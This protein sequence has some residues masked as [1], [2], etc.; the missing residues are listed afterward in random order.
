MPHVIGATDGKHVRIKCPKITGSL[1]HNYKGIF[2][3]VLLAICDANYCFTSFNVGQHGSNNDS[4]VLAHS[5][6]GGYFEDQSNH[7]PQPESVEGCDFDPL[8]YFSVGD[9]Y[10]RLRLG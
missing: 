7:I 9:E 1:Y 8:P 2:S 5:N 10:S 4:S 3:L 6:M